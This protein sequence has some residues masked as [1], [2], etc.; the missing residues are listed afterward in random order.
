MTHRK[1]ALG[2][3]VLLLPVAGYAWLRV[4]SSRTPG[5]APNAARTGISTYAGDAAADLQ[6]R[7]DSGGAKLT[8]E[9][10]RGYIRSLLKN[11]NI[12][13]SS[14]TLVFSKS[15]FQIDHISP[16]SPRALYF[17]DD[18]YVGFVPTG[19]FLEIAAIDPSLG[20]VFYT[21]ERDQVDHPK[22]ET[23]SKTRNCIVCHDSSTSDNSIPRLLM[24]SVLPNPAG[25]SLR[26]AALLTTDQSP[27]NERW[28]GWY[29]TGTHGAQRHLGNMVVRGLNVD[30]PS[31]KDYIPRL[32]L[33]PGANVTDLRSRFD[34]K[35]YPNPNSDIVALMLLAHQTHVHN[36]IT[37]ATYEVQE[38][39]K[40]HP[41]TIDKLV[42]EDGDLLVGAMLF[43]AATAFTDPIVG[44][45]GFAEEFSSRG[46]RD[47]KGRSLKDLDL[48]RRLL[49]YPMSYLI[50]SRSFDAMPAVVKDY[51][52][53]R[54]REIL[55]GQDKT[56]AFAHL[57]ATD[58]MN[59]LDILQ[60]TKPEFAAALK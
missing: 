8:F 25:N 59:I 7:L 29:V 40:L 39:E 30:F 45:S 1:L 52:Y 55:T 5:T 19:Q 22:I 27:M 48:K 43:S 38:A 54:F 58:R 10:G 44:T 28:G 36:L 35:R 50:Y 26:G 37:L 24:L 2:L 46:L 56:P 41:E 32:N 57:S 6:R 21:I 4:Q 33:D 49:K 9:P 17:N 13:E 3:L 20:P 60:E 11:L 16:E 47:S 18:V 51:A 34:T 53:R 31:I 23:Q 12:P 14:Q 42:K 15:S